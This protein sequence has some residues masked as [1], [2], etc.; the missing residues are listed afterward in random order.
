MESEQGESQEQQS[1]GGGFQSYVHA[2]QPK[3]KS[4]LLT[5][6]FTSLKTREETIRDLVEQCGAKWY[7]I[8]EQET[9][10]VTHSVQLIGIANSPT[11]NRWTALWND[12]TNYWVGKCS[13]SYEF[14]QYLSSTE[15][16][17]NVEECTTP[18]PLFWPSQRA[19]REEIMT[20]KVADMSFPQLKS[21]LP[22]RDHLFLGCLYV[23]DSF[24]L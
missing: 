10:P 24:C 6:I 11:N 21:K 8:G 4:P 5:V 2:Q 13:N 22:H 1:E 12:S 15:N 17:H 16:V 9:N 23:D 20:K 18:R 19:K 14:C 3:P 7:M